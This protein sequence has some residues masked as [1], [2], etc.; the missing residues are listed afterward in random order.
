MPKI[1]IT[2]VELQR[3]TGDRDGVATSL[4]SSVESGRPISRA[5]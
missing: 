3:R 1:V 4:L 2:H 5:S